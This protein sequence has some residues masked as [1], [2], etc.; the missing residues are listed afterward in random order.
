MGMKLSCQ[1]QLLPGDGLR[2]KFD[3]ARQAGFDGIELRARGDGHFAGRLP[4]L[5]A[6]VRAG[7]VMRT[8]CPETDHFIG[9]FDAELRRDA[10]AQLRSQISVI[11]ELGGEG[12]LT[13]AS[14]GMFSL[15][16]PPFTPPRSA[17]DDHKVL[18]EALAELGE[19]A[20]SEGV[21]LALEPL[22]RYEDY[23]I[24]R[25]EQAADLAEEVQRE[26]GCDSVRVCADLF[27]MN[28]EEDDLAK[29]ITAVGSRI[30]HVHVDDSNRLQPGTGHL[31]FAAAFGALHQISYDGW[32]ALECQL[33]GDPQTALPA[34]ARFLARFR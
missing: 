25:L 22:N 19:H 21:W 4:E 34:A 7:V 31:D 15:R 1:E 6:A 17:A 24:N 10:V 30:A 9:H 5:R 28:I 13:P 14:W 23:M 2:A 27:H 3:F 12:V 20:A 8:V 18:F 26:L 11:A 32:L 16:L 33:R 29:A